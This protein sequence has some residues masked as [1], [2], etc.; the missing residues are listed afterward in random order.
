MTRLD[1]IRLES[2]FR[3]VLQ[4]ELVPVQCL[5]EIPFGGP[6]CGR[7][8]GH[9]SLGVIH[10]Y[11][12]C[13][14]AVPSSG[15]KRFLA[16][17]AILVLTQT[18]GLFALNA[19]ASSGLTAHARDIRAWAR[20]PAPHEAPSRVSPRGVGLKQP[21]PAPGQS[22]APDPE[23]PGDAPWERSDARK[24]AAPSHDEN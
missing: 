16:G 17:L 21:P 19:L 10:G 18:T 23:S 15:W 13:H 9:L 8:P 7:R 5:A 1:G 11:S 3:L 24:A 6:V 2:D 4:R 20:S 14:I 22:A 12:A